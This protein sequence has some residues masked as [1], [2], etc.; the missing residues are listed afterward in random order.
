MT[1]IDP[2]AAVPAYRREPLSVSNSGAPVRQA[3]PVEGQGTIGFAITELR[4]FTVTTLS[5]LDGTP[6]FEWRV[7][8]TGAALFLHDVRGGS[9]RLL[10]EER[11][12]LDPS[13]ACPYWFS[14]DCHNRAIRYGKGEMRL[15]TML[16]S[17]DLPR[18]VP[19][20]D[21]SWG[22]LRSI[23]AVAISAPIADG[24]DLPW[25]TSPGGGSPFR[26]G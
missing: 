8:Q 2:A 3:L 18:K 20:E 1:Y 11:G 24:I 22:W 13:A 4:A 7:D 23:E 9:T 15:G 25:P 5:N 14:F 12:G 21:D 19:G 17:L 16:A 26:P 10:F 6:T